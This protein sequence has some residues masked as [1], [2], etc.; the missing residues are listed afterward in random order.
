MHLMHQPKMFPDNWIAAARLLHE[1]KPVDELPCSDANTP[2]NMPDVVVDL[3]SRLDIAEL[4][5]EMFSQVVESILDGKIVL[6]D[7]ARKYVGFCPMK[8]KNIKP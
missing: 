4:G 5:S 8:F 7:S 1:T 3:D 2:I 6:I